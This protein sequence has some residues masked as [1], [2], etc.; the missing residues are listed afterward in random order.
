[1]KA[2]KAGVTAR[3][4]LMENLTNSLFATLGVFIMPMVNNSQMY[5]FFPFL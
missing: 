5:V 2:G 4:I 3:T 1:M